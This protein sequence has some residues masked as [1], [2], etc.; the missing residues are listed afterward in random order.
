MILITRTM[1]IA[2][3]KHRDLGRSD[4]ACIRYSVCTGLRIPRGLQLYSYHART[5]NKALTYD[6]ALST[7]FS[8]VGSYS[9]TVVRASTAGSY[10]YSCTYIY[11]CR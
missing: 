4:F 1:H 7:E 8:N 10:E 9:C 5:E 2:R 3:L 11:S 6:L